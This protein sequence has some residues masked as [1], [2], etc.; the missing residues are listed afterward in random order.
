[1]LHLLHFGEKVV[2]KKKNLKKTFDCYMYYAFF[3][4]SDNQV[5]TTF[6]Q[7][8]HLFSRG[9]IFLFMSNK[10]NSQCMTSVVIHCTVILLKMI[11]FSGAA[12][13]LE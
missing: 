11:K 6:V 4:F 10:Y 7:N 13:K 8:L 12:G 3:F 5:K 9:M 2:Y 1:M